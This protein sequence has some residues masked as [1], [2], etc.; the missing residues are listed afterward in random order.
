[1]RQEKLRS[2]TAYLV[3]VKSPAARA[4]IRRAYRG[5]C[6]ARGL[7]PYRGRGTW[8]AR[9]EALQVALFRVEDRLESRKGGQSGNP[10]VDQIHAARLRVE[11]DLGWADW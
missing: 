10:V 11:D 2:V 3:S 4:Q 1:M 6:K 7:D 5:L 8:P 9:R